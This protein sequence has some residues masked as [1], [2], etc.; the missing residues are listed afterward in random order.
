MN[1]DLFYPG[2]VQS[3]LLRSPYSPDSEHGGPSDDDTYKLFGIGEM[4]AY[5]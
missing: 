2:G 1:L 5:G 4:T 3:K